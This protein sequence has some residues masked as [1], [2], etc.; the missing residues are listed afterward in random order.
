MEFRFRK[1]RDFDLG[2]APANKPAVSRDIRAVGLMAQDFPGVHFDMR[3][4]ADEH[5]RRGQT[6][7][8]DRDNPD[9]AFVASLSGRVSKI[10]H[11]ARRRIETIEIT[12][13][14]NDDTRF[15]IEAALEDDTALR[16]LLLQSGAW[17]GIRSR[18]F[19]R[20]PTASARPSAIFVTATDS[21]PLAPEPAH[22]LAPQLDSFTRGVAALLR[23]TEGPVFVCQAFG[24]SLVE[25]GERLR[26]AQ[27]S[28]PHPS[29]LAGTHIHHLWPVSSHRSVW[30][31][32]YQDV[33][34]IGD[35]L[36][37]GQINSQRTISVAG[38]GLSA[39]AL[40]DAALGAE[41]S[42]LLGE[43]HTDADS[44]LV[45]LIS[46]S[47]SSGR[48]TRFLG[49]YDL[50][51]T[52]LNKHEHAAQAR[53]ALG[54][55]FEKLPHKAIGAT[56]PSEAFE[57]LFPFDLLPVPL[58]RALAVGDVESTERLGGLELLEEDMALL[59][60]RCPSGSDY[61]KL[62]RHVLDK[63]DEERAT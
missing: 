46:G 18:P 27:F 41:L 61:G 12:A 29:G 42:G 15:D 37:T 50:Q 28:G 45:R 55:L 54:R 4:E 7:C 5:V 60:W 38:P 30:Q 21:H 36:K 20:I 2:P 62:L 52:V 19:G 25:P 57:R 3:V 32:G 44:A 53:T 10:R 13:E 35:L 48:A 22:V 16:A 63:L 59:S 47:I 58:M 34:A 23:L 33:A 9:I 6:L 43:G 51:L 17:V 14:G 49:R 31:I 40:V 39:P 56:V 8:V 26:V 1:G 11:G 24:P